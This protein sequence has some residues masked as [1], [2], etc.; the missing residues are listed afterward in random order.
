HPD[1]NERDDKTQRQAGK[2]EQRVGGAERDGERQEPLWHPVNQ[3][4]QHRRAQRE[5]HGGEVDEQRGVAELALEAH[6]QAGGHNPDEA[7]EGDQHR[8]VQSRDPEVEHPQRQKEREP[9]AGPQVSEERGTDHADC[10]M[11]RRRASSMRWGISSWEAALAAI[12]PASTA[13]AAASARPALAVSRPGEASRPT[14]SSSLNRSGR[15]KASVRFR[16]SSSAAA[17]ACGAARSAT[18]LRQASSASSRT[19]FGALSRSHT[20]LTSPSL[21]GQAMTANRT[22]TDAF[23]FVLKARR[24]RT[25]FTPSK[26]RSPSPQASSTSNIFSGCGSA[27]PRAN[28]C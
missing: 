3:R 23:A 22:G 5:R 16:S 1:S 10:S 20:A 6:A 13:L 18:R 4:H 7:V 25:G 17:V 24:G 19:S 14:S 15:R 2:L 27:R 9:G 21:C 28:S 26:S 12:A 11:A 8:V